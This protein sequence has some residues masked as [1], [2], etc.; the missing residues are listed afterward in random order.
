MLTMLTIFISVLGGFLAACLT[1]FAFVLGERPARGE[2]VIHTSSHC[3]SCGKDLRLIDNIPVFG[4]LL[5][6]GKAHCCKSPIPSQ[7]FWM[8]LVSGLF[9]GVATYYLLME[10][11]PSYYFNS[12]GPVYVTIAIIMTI[13]VWWRWETMK[14]QERSFNPYIPPPVEVPFDLESNQYYVYARAQ[15][16]RRNKTNGESPDDT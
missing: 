11:T 6:G 10:S 14:E 15:M 5:N 1:S 12:L 8:E 13:S 2:S 4:W 9:G 16:T 3:T 7:Y